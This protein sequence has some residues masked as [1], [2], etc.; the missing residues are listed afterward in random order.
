MGRSPSPCGGII[1]DI[2]ILTD[3]CCDLPQ[4]YLKENKDIVNVLG[5]PILI[6][7]KSFLDDLGEN[8]DLKEFYDRLRGGSFASTSQIA[9][10]IFEEIFQT[11]QERGIKTIYLGLSSGLSGT[12]NSA[13]LAQN[14]VEERTKKKGWIFN[15]NALAGSVGLGVLI[16]KVV[17]LVKEN[18]SAS[19]IVSWIEEHKLEVQHWFAVNDLAYLKRG[20]RISTV[21]A[22]VGTV[23][24]I[25]PILI[26]N[27]QGV[28]KPFQNVRGRKKS[29]K[30]LAEQFKSYRKEDI[31]SLVII[32]HGDCYEDAKALKEEV[33]EF[34]PS[35]QIMISR[36]A[37]T[38][39]SH[40]GPDMLAIAFFGEKRL[41]L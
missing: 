26:V 22:T 31:C 11:N 15:P 32:G 7:G 4:E 3:S 12:L 28:I 39:A 24:N 10:L 35:N 8:T 21:T 9:P 34:F 5:M 23:L 41:D 1:M 14:A 30:F 2:Q 33:Q 40:V 25:K 16:I 38:I 13:I 27:H 36:L 19:K 6:E 18:W 29:I 20:G 37:H 17:E